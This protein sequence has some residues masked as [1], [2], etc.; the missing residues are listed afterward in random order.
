[1][2]KQL[3]SGL[4]TGLLLSATCGT[5]VAVAEDAAAKIQADF[6]ST[7]LGYISSCQPNPDD[8]NY[9]DCISTSSTT[10]QDYSVD[11]SI[12]E[13]M[14]EKDILLLHSSVNAIDPIYY[15]SL[16]CAFVNEGRIVDYYGE[17]KYMLRGSV[18]TV[19]IAEP[20]EKIQADFRST[21]LGYIA[22]CY[23]DSEDEVKCYTHIGTPLYDASVDNAILEERLENDLDILEDGVYAISPYYYRDLGCKFIS[24]SRLLEN[25]YGGGRKYMLR[26]AQCNI[27]LGTP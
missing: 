19:S 25:P 1:M 24:E 22:S 7:R 14:I 23:A 12:L 21:R 8:P 3:L 9:V 15:H 20:A 17:G 2:K 16:E 18:C 10:V 27:D 4:A 26:S 5:S 13:E 6:R 11:N